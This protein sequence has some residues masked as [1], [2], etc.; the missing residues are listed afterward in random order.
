M[1]PQERETHPKVIPGAWEE[2]AKLLT[3]NPEVDERAAVVAWLRH[4]A[5]NDAP[6]NVAVG[7]HHAAR[8]IERGEHRRGQSDEG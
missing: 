4:H 5:D 2:A 3:D 6:Y 1:M 8:A 7:L